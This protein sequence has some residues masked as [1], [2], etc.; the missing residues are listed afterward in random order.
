MKENNSA[1]TAL[2]LRRRFEHVH[3]SKPKHAL[4]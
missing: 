3:I 4:L 2:T 1:T